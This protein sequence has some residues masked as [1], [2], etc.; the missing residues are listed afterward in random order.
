V[1]PTPLRL[2]QIPSA[3]APGTLR[4]QLPK[5]LPPGPYQLRINNYRQGGFDS[6]HRF[7]TL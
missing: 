2:T 3:D 6:V 7:F 5:A 4:L 1:L